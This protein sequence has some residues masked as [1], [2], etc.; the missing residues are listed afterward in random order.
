MDD[1]GVCLVCNHLLDRIEYFEDTMVCDRGPN[2]YV[3]I[4]LNYYITVAMCYD[5]FQIMGNSFIEDN[6]TLYYAGKP[7]ILSSL[8][9]IECTD[10]ALSYE[11]LY[12][13]VRFYV[14]NK[15]FI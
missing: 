9:Y 15:A 3:L 12:K 1:M 4:T 10:K 13:M 6:K 14:R 11:E 2:H 8:S 5:N 7:G